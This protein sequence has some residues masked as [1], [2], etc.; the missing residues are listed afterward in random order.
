MAHEIRRFLWHGGKTN[1]K[2]LHLMKWKIVRLPVTLGG[3]GIKDPIL[4]NIALGEKMV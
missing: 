2:K 4:M 1:S 3:L